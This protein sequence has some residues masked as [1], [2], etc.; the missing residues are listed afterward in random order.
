[1]RS[2]IRGQNVIG[3]FEVELAAQF[4]KINVDRKTRLV[5]GENTAVA[6]KDSSTNR[7]DA[8]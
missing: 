7:C 6:I 8:N 1:M 2:H 4:F 5:L 3:V